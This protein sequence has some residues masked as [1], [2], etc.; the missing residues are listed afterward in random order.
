MRK[1]LQKIQ[2]FILVSGLSLTLEAGTLKVE[3]FYFTAPR[4]GSHMT[5][6]YGKI[7]NISKTKIK[8]SSVFESC[9]CPCRYAPKR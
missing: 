4:P 2:G 8:I 9:C 5:A 3:D 6:A 7:T 1:K